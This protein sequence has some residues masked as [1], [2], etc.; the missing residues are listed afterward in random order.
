[1]S[2]DEKINEAEKYDLNNNK[3]RKWKFPNKTHCSIC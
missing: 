2:I 1:M 3:Y